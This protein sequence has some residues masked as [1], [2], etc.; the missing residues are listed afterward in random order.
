M[1]QETKSTCIVVEVVLRKCWKKGKSM[2]LDARRMARELALLWNLDIVIFEN[3]FATTCSLA[4]R[5][6]LFGSLEISF[7]TNVYG[8]YL[9]LEK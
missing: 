2:V 8:L 7:I 3:L 5:F 4:T 1:L 6:I 9:I